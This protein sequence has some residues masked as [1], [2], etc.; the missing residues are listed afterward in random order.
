MVRAANKNQ[1]KLFV[2]V[3]VNFQMTDEPVHHGL[4]LSH[5]E[6]CDPVQKDMYI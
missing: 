4:H 5:K 3:Q 6:A 1:Q 2:N